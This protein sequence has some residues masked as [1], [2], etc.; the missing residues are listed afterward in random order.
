[1][2][3]A[4]DMSLMMNSPAFVHSQ[5]KKV[6]DS[7]HLFGEKITISKIAPNPKTGRV[8]IDYRRQWQDRDD[9]DSAKNKQR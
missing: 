7:F 4:R 2:D 8:D 9:P 3:G 1:M 5:F 6:G